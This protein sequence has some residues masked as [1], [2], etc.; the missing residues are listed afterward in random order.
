VSVAAKAKAE[1]G[2]DVTS[3]EIESELQQIIHEFAAPAVLS[4]EALEEWIRHP[5]KKRRLLDPK[6]TVPVEEAKTYRRMRI[7]HRVARI[8]FWV[9]WIAIPMFINFYPGE[10]KSF[11]QYVAAKFSW[12]QIAVAALIL[13]VLPLYFGI[14]DLLAPRFRVQK[15]RQALEKLRTMPESRGGVPAFVQRSAVC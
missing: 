9:Y 10:L 8:C 12:P 2:I 14:L 15:A 3:C 11:I 5:P 13:F 6:F 1:L 4:L 7:S